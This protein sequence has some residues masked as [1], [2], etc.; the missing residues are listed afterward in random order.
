MGVI[1]YRIFILVNTP[2]AS[3]GVTLIKSRQQ[4]ITED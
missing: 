4:L 2:E 3:F 1:I